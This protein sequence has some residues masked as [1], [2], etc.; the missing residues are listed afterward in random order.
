MKMN[1]VRNDA[2]QIIKESI[3]SVLPD[4]AVS[5]A[6]KQKEFENGNIYVIAAGKA[7]WQMAKKAS[8]VL[9]ERIT[10]GIVCTKYGHVKGEIPKMICYEGGHP[11]PDENSFIAT[12]AALEL[13]KNLNEQDTVI[14]LLSGGG[15]ALFEVPLVSGDELKNLTDR[16]LACGANIMEINTIRKRLSAVK[17][18]K[19]A[20]LC[21]PAAVY[22]IVLSDVLGDQLD[23]IASGPA[24]SDSSTCED[25]FK[26]VEKYQ[27]QISEKTRECLMMETPKNIT[28]VETVIT[29]SVSKLCEA[30]ECACANLGYR[31]I[32]LTDQLNCQARE[33]GLFLAAIAKSHQESRESLAFIAGGETVVHLTG[34]GKGGR[35]QEL[36]LAAAEEIS[37]LK[38]TAIFSVGSDG[39]DGPTDAAGGYCDGNTRNELG[40]IG[41]SIFEVLRDNDAYHALEKTDGLIKTGA[42]GTN[43]NDVAVVLIKR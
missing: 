27:L 16:L 30:A 11:I 1:S 22:S 31:T 10:K 42:T 2:E 3:Q 36:A 29:G 43:V 18:G 19:F 37:G 28:N 33:A 12:R 24:C 40:K 20:K 4:K 8:E 34:Q 26:I 32:I 35:N 41:I 13:V 14:F 7:A 23:V 25:A 17:G 9:E 21:E 6:L 39:T 15:S 38:N 5:E